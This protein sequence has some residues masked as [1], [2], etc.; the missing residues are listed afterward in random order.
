M[1]DTTP[2]LPQDLDLERVILGAVLIREDREQF[3]KIRREIDGAITGPFH[4][5]VLNALSALV[6]RGDEINP[7]VLWKELEGRGSTFKDIPTGHK[8]WD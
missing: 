3:E 2:L 1:R 7:M 8:W 4:R 6:D 5:E